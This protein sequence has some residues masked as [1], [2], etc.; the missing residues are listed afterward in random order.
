MALRLTLQDGEPVISEARVFPNDPGDPEP[1]GHTSGIG[2]LAMGGE[3]GHDPN[4]VPRGGLTTRMIRQVRTGDLSAAVHEK[5]QDLDQHFPGLLGL[6]GGPGWA[7]LVDRAERQPPHETRVQRLART[8][9]LYVDACQRDPR[10]A[11]RL[12]AQQLGIP[13][14]HVRDRIYAARISGLLTAGPGRGRAGGLLTAQ[15]QEVLA[16]IEPPKGGSDG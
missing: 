12:V 2:S 11:N 13:V 14:A 7:A 4:A 1:S 16:A 5:A 6:A 10:H 15:A 8:A 3:W 9:A